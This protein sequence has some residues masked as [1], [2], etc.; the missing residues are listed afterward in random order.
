MC[1]NT[2][3]GFNCSCADG[4]N[5]ISGIFCVGKIVKIIHKY[6]FLCRYQ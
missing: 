2:I 5:L 1:T 4:Y 6:N 3:G